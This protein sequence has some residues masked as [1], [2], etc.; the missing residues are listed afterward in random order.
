MITTAKWVLDI[1]NCAWCDIVSCNYK[2]QYAWLVCSVSV[3][4]VLY[5]H[6]GLGSCH[7]DFLRISVR[8]FL[9]SFYVD[10]ILYPEH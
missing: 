2:V 9:Y 10:Y 4:S 5:L 1:I 7:P 3:S 6:I 8:T